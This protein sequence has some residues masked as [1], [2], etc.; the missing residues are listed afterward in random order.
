[1]R[2]MKIV[3]VAV[4][5]LS[6][7]APAL[8]GQAKTITVD[9]V[10]AS[11]DGLVVVRDGIAAAPEGG[12]V[13][14]MLAMIMYGGNPELGL[15]A[16]TLALDM[17][18]LSNGTVYKGF[19]PN[20]D[21]NDRFAQIDLFPFLGKIYVNGTKTADGYTLPKGPLAFTVTEVRLQKDGSAKVFVATTSGNMPRPLTLAKNDKGLWKVTEASSMFVGPSA[22]PPVKET[23]EL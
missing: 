17:H 3:T 8:S 15:Q 5:V 11:I 2:M 13:V 23:D 9:S 4:M 12:V 14:F 7:A 1:M 10:P 22:L 21:W 18:E 16:F 6:A 19:R 20:R